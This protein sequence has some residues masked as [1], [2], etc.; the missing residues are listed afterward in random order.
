MS[1]VAQATWRWDGRL[2][3]SFPYNRHVVEA[4]KIH[5]PASGRE[6]VPERKVW[7]VDPVYAN[8]AL[9]LVQ[10]IY[11]DLV[12]TDLRQDRPP[13][14]DSY[15]ASDPNYQRLH[16]LPSAPL[17]VIDAAYKALARIHHPDAVP[18]SERNHANEV[19][20][21]LNEAYSVLRDRVAS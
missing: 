9:R 5:I 16:L 8:P 3:L 10:G 17:C 18:P 6:W 13:R 15:Q 19:M 2:E 21:A 12:I 14:T 20:L 4:L 1:M 11:G 7:I